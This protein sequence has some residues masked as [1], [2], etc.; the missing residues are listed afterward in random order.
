MFFSVDGMLWTLPCDIKRSA[1][2]EESD[3]SGQ[4][5]GGNF[6]RDVIGTY[7]DYDV[8]LVP[9]PQDMETYYEMYDK[10]TE[11]V[12][13]HIFIFPFN[14]NIIQLNCKVESLNDVY[15]RMPNG[16]IYWKG[17]NFKAVANVPTYV[18]QGGTVTVRGLAP[19]PDIENP[20]IGDTY[21]YT[22]DGWRM[23]DVEG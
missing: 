12:D 5:V 13:G 23:V 2:T 18:D 19:V 20:S 22:K 4:M 21:R 15:V 14:A 6:Y 10:L 11:P 9:N 3:L 17:I 7:F 1:R 8:T 16:G